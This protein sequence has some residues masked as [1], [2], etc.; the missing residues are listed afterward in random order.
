VAEVEASV[1]QHEVR[2]DASPETVFHFFTDPARIVEWKGR[3]AT[4]DPRP[5]GVYRVEIRD[6]QVVVGQY[7]EITPPSRVVFTWGWEDSPS[8]PPGTSTVEI[9][10]VPDG[11]GT[12][13]RLTHRDLPDS[14]RD[15]HVLGWN[16]YLPR[17]AQAAGGQAPGPDPWDV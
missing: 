12:I 15:A 13:V 5:G 8:L 1:L 10:L 7:V 3:S 2:I 11:P 17:L 9:D 4:L 14:L 6:G 16:H